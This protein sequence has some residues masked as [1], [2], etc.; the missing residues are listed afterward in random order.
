LSDCVNFMN[1][2]L[3]FLVFN[4]PD[5]TSLV[6][7]AIRRVK[8]ARLYVAADGARGDRVGEIERCAEV[9]RIATAVDW[10]CELKTLFRDQNIGCRR[11]VSGAIDWFFEHEEE[12]VIL[13][14]D[15][16]PDPSWFGF[17]EELLIKYRED[18]RVM[19]VSASHYHREAHVPSDSYFFSRYNHCW[20]WASWRR[21]WSLFDRDMK[22]WPSL[23]ESNWLLSI[24]NGNRYFKEYWT[25]IFDVAYEDKRVDSWAYRWTF[26]CWSQNGLTVLPAK[27]LVKNIGFGEDATHTSAD[28]DGIVA[29]PLERMDFPLRHPDIVVC[30]VAAD[31]WTAENIF[32]INRWNAVKSTLR[33]LPVIGEVGSV[34]WRWIKIVFGIFRKK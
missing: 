5:T 24:G 27:N 26:S 13:E 18:S 9:R 16:L 19:C 6:F 30:D 25:D 7:D 2:P 1:T 14:D 8:P 4:R 31:Q 32:K 22:N 20:G 28:E 17:A 11:A 10:P 12:G 21:A 33:K 29:P 23:R 34:G 3:L 15:C